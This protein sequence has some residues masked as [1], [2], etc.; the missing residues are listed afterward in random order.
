M[1]EDGRPANDPADYFRSEK[2]WLLQSVA[3]GGGEDSGELVDILVEEG[4][5]VRVE[6]NIGVGGEVGLIAGEGRRVTPGRIS[7]ERTGEGEDTVGVWGAKGGKRTE[8]GKG[9][10][11]MYQKRGAGVPQGGGQQC[12]QKG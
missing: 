6:A 8:R 9:H 3:V 1:T 7:M 2:S 10:G 4:K 12:I 11:N 5:I